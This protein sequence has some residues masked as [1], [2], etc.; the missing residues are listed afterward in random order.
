MILT[1]LAWFTSFLFVFLP[2]VHAL[3]MVTC[4]ENTEIC[5]LPA[6]QLFRINCNCTPSTQCLWSRFSAD[7]GE[8]LSNDSVL[9]WQGT[10]TGYGQYICVTRDNSTPVRNIM[11]LPEGKEIK[12]L[13]VLYGIYVHD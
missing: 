1:V 10:S 3:Q 6:D 8:I 5:S 12:T 7:R 11:I 2:K 13:L 4:A 9:M